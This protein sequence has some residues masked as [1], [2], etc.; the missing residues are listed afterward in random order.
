MV[1]EGFSYTMLWYFLQTVFW[2]FVFFAT[3]SAARSTS[4]VFMFIAVF[5]AMWCWF[6]DRRFSGHPQGYVVTAPPL[7]DIEGYTAYY[8][9]LY[10][11]ALICVMIATFLGGIVMVL[12]RR[13]G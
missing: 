13:K 11:D 4:G 1:A 12:T 8:N 2:V 5:I 10:L 9:S 3:A 6:A 7:S